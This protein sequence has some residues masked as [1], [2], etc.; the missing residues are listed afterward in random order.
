MSLAEISVRRPVATTMACLVVIVLGAIAFTRL[1]IDLLPEVTFPSLT[2]Q[3]SYQNVGPQ[4]VEELITRPVEEAMAAIAGVE[5]IVSTSSEGQSTVRIAFTWGTD[6]DEAANEVRTRIDRIRGMLP[7]D[8]DAPRVLKFDLDQFPILFLGVSSTV[9]DQIDLREFVDQQVKYRIERVPGVA[10]VDLRGGLQRQVQ[11]NLNRDKL[12]ALGLSAD[13]VTTI[14]RQENLNRPAGKV[15]EGNSNIYLRTVGEFEQVEEIGATVMAVRG[16]SPVYLRDVADVREGVEEIVNIVRINGEP[17]MFISI[18]KQSGSNTVEVA[19]SVLREVER[20]NADFAEVTI[21]PTIDTSRYIKNSIDNVRNAAALGGLLAIII[22]FFFL[23]SGRSTL[24]IATAIPISV[25]ATFALI[26]FTG[27][28]LNIMTFGGLALGVGMLVDN[29]VVV[30]ENIY[31]R[32]EAGDDA[33]LSAVIGTREVASAITAS[34]I[35]TMA[36]FLPVVFMEGISSVMYTQLAIVVAFA[37]FASLAV[38]LTLIPM[39]SS[40]LLAGR[41]R[42]TNKERPAWYQ[43]TTDSSERF[44]SWLETHYRDRVRWAL[45]NRLIIVSGALGLFLLSLMFLPYI[46]SEL[47]PSTDEGEVRIEVEMD[48]NAR[49]GVLDDTFREVERVVRAEVPEAQNMITNMGSGGWRGASNRGNLR[50][51]LVPQAE[52]SRSSAQIADD[53]RPKLAHI[54]GARITT[55]EGSGLFILR[56]A[57][58]GDNNSNLSLELR[59][60]DLDRG[61]GIAAEIEQAIAGISGITDVRIGR[62]R[63][64]PERAIRIDRERIARLGLNVSQVAGIIETNLSGS[65]ATVLRRGGREYDVIVRL[66]ETH[67]EFL[68]DIDNIS[69]VAANGESVPLRSVVDVSFA[70]GPMAIDRKDQER[71]IRINANVSGRDMGSVAADI[72]VAMRQL[73]I[74]PDFAVVVGGEYEEQ[75]R[76]QRQLMIALLLALLLVYMVMAAQFENLLDPFVVMFSIPLALI[77]VLLT[78]FI[79]NTTF[80]IQSYIGMVMLA[81][82]VVNN[83]IVLVDYINLMRREHGWSL[84]E[85]VIESG[86]RRLRP[87][88]MTTLT[89]L[90]GLMPLAIGFGEGAEVQ[91]AMARVVIGGLL[92]STLITLLFIPVLYTT[93]AEWQLAWAERRESRYQQ[94]GA[95][96]Q[97]SVEPS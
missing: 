78:M 9:L 73:D 92:V 19:E 77:G 3:T 97:L 47:M 11:V 40:K 1:P 76:A 89:T 42:G 67:R 16:G 6:L 14:L 45:D 69:L 34:T 54:P 10:A 38:A 32:H 82:I 58:G 87:I 37:L 26:Y 68:T 2:V 90:L 21:V 41:E 55:R 86:R 52:R 61:Y 81:G 5:E 51:A 29:A 36:V 15:E 80:N 18:N 33:R 35:T 50:V 75:Q 8:A 30:L 85:A 4:E 83:A 53:L 62:D 23:R 43:K 79:T 57:F 24:V 96:P 74:P 84:H 22:L 17:G 91:A 72:R 59:G 70:R 60:H 71:F 66:D 65:R 7:D 25:I 46:G 20:L 88:L 13:R 27:Y 63:A 31:R 95:A 48:V 93:F 12:L 28:T 44:M 64:R 39:L 94:S 49:L 56:M